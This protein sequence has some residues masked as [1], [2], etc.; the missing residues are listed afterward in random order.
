MSE[1]GRI[2]SFE[3]FWAFY[4]GEHRSPLNRFLHYVG[5]S[6]G[7]ALIAIAV[8]TQV[9]WLLALAPIFGYGHAWVGHFWVEKNKPA[10]FA[11]P[12]WSFMG[13]LK[14][15][16]FALMGRMGDEVVRLYGSRH[17]TPDAPCRVTFS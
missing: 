1:T 2:Q 7:L 4:V 3:E 12:G 11:Y 16:A 6:A 5:T 17:P 13:D 10:S 9:W 15:L 8:A 14:M